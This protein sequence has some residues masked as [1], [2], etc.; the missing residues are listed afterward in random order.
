MKRY[1]L[2]ILSA[3]AL[4]LVPAAAFAVSVPQNIT[5]VL[6]SDGS[7][8]G[9]GTGASFDSFSESGG[10][11]TFVMN[12]GDS[13]DL[14]SSAKKKLTNSKSVATECK[15]SESHIFISIPSNESQTTVTVTP[16]GTCT[17]STESG[18]GSTSSSNVGGS[19]GGSGGGGYTGWTPS[20]TPAPTVA[21]VVVAQAPTTSVPPATVPPATPFG[22]PPSTPVPT[23]TFVTNLTQGSSGSDAEA[24]QKYLAGDPS[25]YPEGIVNGY[26][27]PKTK[28]AVQRFQE[29][30]GITGPGQPGYGSVGPK[31]RAKLNELSGKPAIPAP[32]PA[33]PR[34]TAPA[35]T[36]GSL[37]LT[38]GLVV[39]SKGED[40]KALQTYLMGYPGFFPPDTDITGYY[41]SLT[42]TAVQQFQEKYGI[43]QQG[44]A[45]Y[46]TVGPKTRAKLNELTK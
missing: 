11:F 39:G 31:T 28:A 9:L 2:P 27:G 18:G 19:S 16:T 14:I 36:S 30:Y 44:D 46:G 1:L 5:L 10:T 26:F 12:P 21:P 4:L 15:T 8:Y 6:S 3:S 38:R 7:S 23:Y 29:K 32:A 20:S 35:P 37:N 24:L 42:R 13:I 41:G 43:A 34:V 25:V 40:V 22:T 33:T 17:T 45:G